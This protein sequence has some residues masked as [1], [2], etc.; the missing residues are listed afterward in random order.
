[1]KRKKMPVQKLVGLGGENDI[2]EACIMENVKYHTIDTVKLT[3][4]EGMRPIGSKINWVDT[5]E[6]HNFNFDEE[7]RVIV[8]IYGDFKGELGGLGFYSATRKDLAYWKRRTYIL[9]KAMYK[10]EE[11][12]R[13]EVE[14][15]L[16]K[17]KLGESEVDMGVVAFGM[18]LKESQMVFRIV[19]T[20]LWD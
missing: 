13:D 15:V 5:I 16:E 2:L 14:K 17:V 7:D 19:M 1:M 10:K 18:L 6:E 20:Y 12:V 8:G 3:T 9:M 11:K 4:K